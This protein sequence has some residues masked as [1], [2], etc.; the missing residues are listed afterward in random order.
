MA[1]LF[2]MFGLGP[3]EMAAVAL[4]AVLLFGRR[5]PEVGRSIGKSI[6]EFKKGMKDVEAEVSQSDSGPKQ[7]IERPASTAPKFVPPESEPQ[8]AE[9]QESAAPANS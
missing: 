8:S 2:A 6:V 4:V 9:S 3:M 1:G 7:S 5:L